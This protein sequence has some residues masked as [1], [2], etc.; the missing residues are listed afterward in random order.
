MDSGIFIYIA[1]CKERF[2]A[3]TVKSALD[4]ATHPNRI[5]FG[6]FNTVLDDEDYITDPI[7]IDQPKNKIFLV[8]AKSPQ[9]LGTGFSRMAASLLCNNIDAEYAL[10]IDA[11]MIFDKDWDMNL[12]KRFEEVSSYAGTDKIVLTAN[13]MP[14]VESKDR[15][16]MLLW[17]KY[18]VNPYNF[19]SESPELHN[20]I[21]ERLRN[22]VTA[23]GFNSQGY[24]DVVGAPE[25]LHFPPGLDYVEVSAIHAAYMFFKTSDIRELL[26]DPENTFEGDQLNY[27]LR[28]LSRGYKIF[29]VQKP[30]LLAKDKHEAGGSGVP[31]DTYDWRVASKS[32]FLKF[33]SPERSRGLQSDM[34]TGRYYGYW[35]APDEESLK[36]A[37][38]KMG[39]TRYYEDK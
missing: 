11:H 8:E 14:W 30:V 2:L 24:P 10:Q 21:G 29:C 32:C 36:M 25:H 38:E 37:K 23:F 18:P 27:S 33:D 26:H 15:S 39:L 13:P 1:A 34:F 9:A 17:R 4:N 16:Q 31:I 19:D 6:I 3:Q 22:G 35:G 12:I 5:F 7:I 20:Q 28:V